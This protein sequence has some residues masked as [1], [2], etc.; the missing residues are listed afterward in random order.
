MTIRIYHNPRCSKSRKAL[1]LLN[2]VNQDVKVIQYLKT[3]LTEEELRGI[4]KKMV[5]ASRDFI[6]RKEVEF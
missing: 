4:A 3:P 1:E 5:L 6:R 2:E